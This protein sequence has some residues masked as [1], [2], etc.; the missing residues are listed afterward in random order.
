M[1]SAQRQP[2][3]TLIEDAIKKAMTHAHL[4][5]E[6]AK[7]LRENGFDGEIC[8]ELIRECEQTLRF[9]HMYQAFNNVKKDVT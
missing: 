4:A 6:T 3:D 9:A 2:I 1:T 7:D 5:K 8:G